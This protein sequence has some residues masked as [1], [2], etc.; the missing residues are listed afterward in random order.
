MN[1]PP[2]EGRFSHR[3]FL[4]GLCDQGLSSATTVALTVVSAR[5]LGPAGLG[6]VAI[7][8]AVLLVPVGLQRA[9]VIEPYLTRAASRGRT[10]EWA[11]GA[12]L[13]ASAIAGIA[14]S[15][16]FTVIGI[17]VPGTIGIGFA[18]FAPWIVPVLV[19]SLLRSAVFRHSTGGLAAMSSALWLIGFI[20]A[21]AISPGHTVR[22][23]IANWGVG[24]VLAMSVLIIILFRSA[25]IPLRVT[26][27]R[28]AMRW[29]TDEAFPFGRWLAL[30]STIY[31]TS[32]YLLM[33]G[34]LETLGASAVG[35][36]RAVESAFSPVSLLA[37]GLTNPGMQA[38]RDAKG[39]GR[40]GIRIATFI[41][42]IS[43][44]LTLIYAGVVWQARG[45][46]FAI[47]GESFRRYAA[48]VLPVAIGQAVVASTVGYGALLKVY[49]EGRA[50]LILGILYPFPSLCCALPLAA[51]F[52]LRAAAWGIC[53]G[54]IPSAVWAFSVARR[55][56]RRELSQK[57]ADLCSSRE[58]IE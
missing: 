8:Y 5:L 42:A 39:R 58:L 50:V 1:D 48:L 31:S 40:G 14:V 2:N 20:G 33:S 21:L 38:I 56:V 15:G 35:G 51:M 12:A 18:A 3:Q 49:R 34:L 28:E 22:Q 37:P 9:L 57:G 13:I 11:L 41:S 29:L 16:L 47:Y 27:L 44:A 6:A 55:V 10:D 43:A 23:I 26:R 45:L 52:G 4:W 36:Y 53:A 25:T 54:A 30:S 17:V 24:A 19:F 32:T 7:G 46:V